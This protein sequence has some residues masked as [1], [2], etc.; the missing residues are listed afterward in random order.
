MNVVVIITDTLRRDYLGLYGN[1]SVRTPALDRFS[2]RCVVFDRAYLAS[3]PTMPARADIYT[4]KFTAPYLG[5]GPLPKDEVILPQVLTDAGYRTAAMVDTPF[6]MRDQYGYDRGFH[7]FDWIASQGTIHEGGW[8]KLK[9]V[10]EIQF[11]RQYESDY[12]A[13]MT[14]YRAERWIERHYKDRFFVFVDTW[15][16]HEPW[17]PPSHYVEQYYPRWDGK[18][19]APV[20]DYCKKTGVKKK[21]LDIARACYAGE[22]TMVDRAIGRL[23]ERI[24]SLDLLR[25]TLIVIMSDHGFYFGEH[26][27]FGKCIF[28]EKGGQNC[29]LGAPL[30]EEVTRL[31]LMIFLPGAKPRRTN[32]MVQTHDLMPTILDLVGIEIPD[33][34]Q[35]ISAAPIVRTGGGSNRSWGVS[36]IPLYS[37]GEGSRVVDN[38]M[39]MVAADLQATITAGH[40]SMLYACQGAPV[41]LYNLKTDPQQKKN[42]AE[43]YP[44]IVSKLHRNFYDLIAESGASEKILAPRKRL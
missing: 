5:W 35:G 26:G 13:P 1:K 4:G 14:C 12:C 10:E 22:V 41:E 34:V 44:R 6:H 23:I 15:D 17:D 30:Y 37:P 38:W 20:Y 29:I 40:W 27:I 24:E 18:P 42:L 3:F 11:E 33:T 21:E 9:P 43:K 2:E 28:G 19:I 32:A 25:N 39:R 8:R 16:P 7:E 31:P 36:T